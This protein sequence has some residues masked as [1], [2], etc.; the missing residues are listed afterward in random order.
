MNP[1]HFQKEIPSIE[2][3]KIEQWRSWLKK[4]HLK[5]NKVYVIRYKNHTPTPSPSTMELM[6]EAISWGWI[7]TT[8]HGIDKDKYMIKYSR[9]NEKT[10]K[11]S[12]NTL[13]YAKSLIKQGRM[14]P[15]GL[16]MY[17]IGLK[18]K[19]HD[20]GIPPN[21]KMPLEL[22]EALNKNKKAKYNF[23]SIPPSSRRMFY[24]W[25]LKAKTPETKNKRIK[26]IINNAIN[27]DK[28]LR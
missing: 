20:Y 3:F 22:K 4:N 27:K 7:D 25:I 5:E 11:W 26:Q 18:K 2:V 8:T 23:N 15:H 24:R 17:K 1:P 10:S 16:T 14:S 19:P 6:H 28:T 13:R 21:P 12:K 9:R